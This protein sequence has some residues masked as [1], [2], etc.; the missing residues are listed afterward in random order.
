MIMVVRCATRQTANIAFEAVRATWYWVRCTRVAPLKP[1]RLFDMGLEKYVVASAI[2]G[3]LAQR[4]PPH[5]RPLLRNESCRCQPSTCS[6]VFARSEQ[7]PSRSASKAAIIRFSGRTGIFELISADDRLKDLVKSGTTLIQ[8]Q[9][10]CMNEATRGF[11][12]G[13]R[14]RHAGAHHRG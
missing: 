13:P 10:F 4:Y 9:R 7:T 2:N 14:A 11:E 5:L 12:R 8:L 6:P 3:M 1:H